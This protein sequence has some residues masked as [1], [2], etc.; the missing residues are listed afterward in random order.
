MLL[1]SILE[2]LVT[3]APDITK[4]VENSIRKQ[5]ILK[6]TI[7]LYHYGSGIDLNSQKK[8]LS[9]IYDIRSSIAHGG[10]VKKSAKE[11]QQLLKDLFYYVKIVF[12]TYV[13]D[14]SFVEFLK[15]N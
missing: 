13:N 7:L 8:K 5:F 1:V 11:V 4:N 12:T 2:L 3:H 10:E 9:D 6:L 14:I 15:A